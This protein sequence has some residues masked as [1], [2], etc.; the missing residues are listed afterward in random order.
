MSKSFEWE[1]LR[2]YTRVKNMF[3]CN[4]VWVTGRFV[5]KTELLI[6]Y[7]HLIIRNEKQSNN[8]RCLHPASA[9]H[10]SPIPNFS[11]HFSSAVS[12]RTE[13]KIFPAADSDGEIRSNIYHMKCDRRVSHNEEMTLEQNFVRIQIS[14]VLPKQGAKTPSSTEIWC[15]NSDIRISMFAVRCSHNTNRKQLICCIHVN[16]FAL[17]TVLEFSLW[18]LT[19][20]RKLITDVW[21]QYNYHVIE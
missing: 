3:S 12:S 7:Y 16:G 21:R 2:A 9:L 13:F 6:Y 20:M 10:C 17:L 5:W 19:Q 8:V 18:S 11:R 15:N 14:C 1:T 4:I